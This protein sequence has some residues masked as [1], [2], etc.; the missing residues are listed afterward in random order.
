[1]KK[2]INISLILLLISIVSGNIFAGDEED[3]V[4]FRIKNLGMNVNGKFEDFKTKI[5]YDKDN[6][7]ESKFVGVIQV[8]SV[9]TG[10]NKRDRHLREDD[11]FD[12]EKYPLIKF[13]STSVKKKDDNTLTVE[14]K[15]TIKDVTKTVTLEVDVQQSGDQHIFSTSIKIDRLDYNVGSS[16]MATG[17][18]V[19][20]DIKV[21]H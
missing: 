19:H 14:G 3:H 4:K 9:N 10:I 1:M 17:D 21:K 15:L 13:K 2:T 11:Y 8:E 20:I 7:S 18:D 12:V 6:P 5:E 16:S